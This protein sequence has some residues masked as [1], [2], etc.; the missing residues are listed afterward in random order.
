MD[1][2]A[3]RSHEPLGYGVIWKEKLVVRSAIPPVWFPHSGSTSFAYDDTRP[4]LLPPTD[5]AP[6]KTRMVVGREKGS[7]KDKEA[8][9]RTWMDDM[10][11]K[12]DN[13]KRAG[14]RE[15]ALAMAS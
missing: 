9:K 7:C 10:E 3:E 15:L 14:R 4:V 6:G 5:A 8:A 2:N 1:P 11:Q 13:R 12:Q